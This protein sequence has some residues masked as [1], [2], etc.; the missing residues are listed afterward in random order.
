MDEVLCENHSTTSRNVY[1]KVICLRL[2]MRKVEIK[3]WKYK[4]ILLHHIAI[5][6][7][8]A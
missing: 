6:I 8:R 1:S 2:M 7:F 4:V 5:H 3:P